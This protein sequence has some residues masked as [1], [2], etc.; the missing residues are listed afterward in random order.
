MEL[1]GEVLFLVILS[2]HSIILFSS[3]FDADGTKGCGMAG[4]GE[5][6][7]PEAE[8]HGHLVGPDPNF[9]QNL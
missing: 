2:S 4:V 9:C 7:C 6:D 1:S 5:E 8:S 3:E